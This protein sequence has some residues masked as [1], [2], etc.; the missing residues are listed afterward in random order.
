MRSIVRLTADVKNAQPLRVGAGC[1]KHGAMQNEALLPTI[2]PD[3]F[4]SVEIR[5]GRVV[6][7]QPFP[8]ARKPA[9]KITVDFGPGIGTRT[10]SAQVTVHYTPET[11]LGRLV[12][13][14]VNAPEK[15]I[16]GFASQFLLLGV[17]D[18]TGAV[19]L[20]H[21]DGTVPVGGRVC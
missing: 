19:C 14:W 6:D 17:H 11:L 7:V 3:T 4:F 16:A 1:G 2:A 8:E 13:G 10:T 21:V 15:R 9:Y 5:T 12:L 20:I 18:E